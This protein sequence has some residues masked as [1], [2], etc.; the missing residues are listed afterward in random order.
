[1]RAILPGLAFAVALA[2]AAKLGSL[3]TGGQVS[4]ILLRDPARNPVAEPR[5]RRA[6]AE[7][8]LEFASLRL[9]GSASR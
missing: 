9:F 4:A 1:M 5:E 2:I 7:P 3:A 6:W 8:G